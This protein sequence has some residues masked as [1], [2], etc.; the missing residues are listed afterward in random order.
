M[1]STLV[2]EA[3]GIGQFS[4]SCLIK[5]L[6]ISECG[7]FFLEWAVSVLYVPTHKTQEI[8]ISKQR[9]KDWKSQRTGKTVVLVSFVST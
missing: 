5:V 8:E 2:E 3:V 6:R 7:L 9:E 4:N 1:V